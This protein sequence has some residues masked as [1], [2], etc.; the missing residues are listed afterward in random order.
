MI[1]KQQW[2]EILGMHV[3]FS[4]PH[5]DAKYIACMFPCSFWSATPRMIVMIFCAM[6]SITDGGD[7]TSPSLKLLRNYD[8]LNPNSYYIPQLCVRS[9]PPL[10]S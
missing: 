4:L 8:S 3:H 2:T 10:G 1:D 9:H 5:N 7:D 6:C